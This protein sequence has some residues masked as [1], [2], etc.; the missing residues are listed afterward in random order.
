VLTLLLEEAIDSNIIRVLDITPTIGDLEPLEL[1]YSRN[2]GVNSPFS[3]EG[4]L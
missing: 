3:I 1:D 2:I 4:P